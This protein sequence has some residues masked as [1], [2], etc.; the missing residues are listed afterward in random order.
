M[1]LRKD[2]YHEQDAIGEIQHLMDLYT[3]NKDELEYTAMYLEKRIVNL[4]IKVK[5]KREDFLAF[6]DRHNLKANLFPVLNSVLSDDV[7]PDTAAESNIGT[8]E[9]EKAMR[10][11]IPDEIFDLLK[12]KILVEVQYE[13][14]DRIDELK[15]MKLAK[16]QLEGDLLKVKRVLNT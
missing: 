15:K 7:Y 10:K 12:S 5:S 6:M 2:A 11:N 3:G 14:N 8:V 9:V 13:V 4:S 16:A 1:N